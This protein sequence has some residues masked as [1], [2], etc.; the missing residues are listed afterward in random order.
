MKDLGIDWGNIKMV[1][2]EIEWESVDLI[3][4]A[5]DRGQWW[6]FVNTVVNLWVF[7]SCREFLGYLSNRLSRTVMYLI[8]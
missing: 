2:K 4:L 3:H 6:A 1:L 5:E 7:T 8:R